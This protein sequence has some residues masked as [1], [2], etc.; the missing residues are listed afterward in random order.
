L[1]NSL[2]ILRNIR[3]TP[4]T[5]VEMNKSKLTR[6]LS[7]GSYAKPKKYEIKKNGIAQIRVFKGKLAEDHSGAQKAEMMIN[8]Q[9]KKIKV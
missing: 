1:S 5:P 9:K 7:S 8:E 3:A 6:T 4:D 2:T